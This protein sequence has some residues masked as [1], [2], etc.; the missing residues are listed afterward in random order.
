M[1]ITT[2]LLL[3]TNLILINTNKSFAIEEKINNSLN[4]ITQINSDLR[5]SNLNLKN[6]FA[7]NN[8]NFKVFTIEKNK[9]N[10]GFF[11]VKDGTLESFYIGDFDESELNNLENLSPI[12]S[13]DVSPIM[14]EI[15]TTANINSSS[16]FIP[17]TLT[18][19]NYQY[20][21]MSTIRSQIINNCPFYYNYPYG[22]VDG[23]CVPTSG[24]ML[25]SF[26]DRY[27]I[28]TNLIDGTLPLNHEDNKTA[29]DS[30]INQLAVLMNT[31]K[32]GTDINNE[33]SGLRQY[34]K[35]RGYNNTYTLSHTT[36]KDY[37]NFINSWHQ[38]TLLGVIS[39]SS[40]KASAHA[41]LGVGSAQINNGTNLESYMITHYNVKN[42]FTGDYYVKSNYFDDSIFLATKSES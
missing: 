16:S 33:K 4:S 31:T 40:N 25:L 9:Q 12:F 18:I 41:V 3:V 11:I 7:L 13:R 39:V 30:L 27:S 26:Y 28:L 6:Q 5:G 42:S 35:Q 24:A 14:S 38:P 1:K 29:V 34:I 10:K 21:S 2:I 19:D 32:T 37:E 23:G 36:F 17:I 8:K 20:T 15:T 22:P